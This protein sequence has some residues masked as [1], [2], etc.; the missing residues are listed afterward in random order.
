MAIRGKK[1]NFPHK[2]LKS[3]RPLVGVGI[4]IK[5]KNKILLLKRKGSHGE[6]EWALPGGYHEFAESLKECAVREVK[7]ETGLIVKQKDLKFISLSEQRTFIKTDDKHFI[8]MGFLVEYKGKKEPQI[9]EPEKCQTIA[10]FD[11]NHLPKPLFI[12]SRDS[13]RNLKKKKVFTS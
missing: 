7:E 3:K 8:T 10:W 4:I 6:G 13:L 2:K 1:Q 5:R 9:G 11:L 12:P